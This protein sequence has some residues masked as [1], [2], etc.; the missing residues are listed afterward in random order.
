[1]IT[2]LSILQILLVYLPSATRVKHIIK[3]DQN[4]VCIVSADII[5]HHEKYLDGYT[6]IE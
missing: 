6:Q 4:F 1:M 5:K 3:D 2:P